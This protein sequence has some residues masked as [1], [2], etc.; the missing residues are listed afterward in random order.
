MIKRIAGAVATAVA[1]PVP[2]HVQSLRGQ[3]LGE[4][5]G[6]GSPGLDLSVTGS[7]LTRA[8]IFRRRDAR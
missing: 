3:W 2:Y 5:P 1:T 4:T 8:I 7:A 6:G